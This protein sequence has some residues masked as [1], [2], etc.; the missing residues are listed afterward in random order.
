M[1]AT[2]EPAA[3]RIDA[4][5]HVWDLTVR[6]QPWT[7]ALPTLRRSFSMA[8]LRPA[9][10]A[11]GIRAT[12]VVETVDSAEETAELLS[13]ADTD[14]H[15]AGVVGWVDL[16]APDVAAEIERLRG[17]VGGGHLVG[18]RHQVQS[19]PDTGWLLR[20]DVGRG[21]RALGSAGLTYDFVVTADQLPL[22]I[23]A[24]RRNPDVRF[25]LD[26]A[27]K[28]RIAA[29]EIDGWRRD[30]AE[31]AAHQNVAVKLSGL[32]TEADPTCWTIAQLR[33]YADALLDTF[34]ANRVLFGSDWPVCLLA[35]AYGDVVS[36]ADQLVASLTPVE[37]AGVFGG[38]ALRWYR[39]EVT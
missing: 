13:L 9:L 28:P 17:G 20:D 11:A 4:H 5:H 36:V 16:T 10:E 25:V 24:V 1:T 34:G 37:R 8:D 22:V 30:V 32:V 14:P 29:G 19:E 26:H 35:A 33:P 7:R 23:K 31:L 27:G 6:D 38:N 12:V 3:V 39:L 21:L 2:A 18:V 15:V